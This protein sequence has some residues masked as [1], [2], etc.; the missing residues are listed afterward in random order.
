MD[1]KELKQT[2]SLETVAKDFNIPITTSHGRCPCPFC[3]SNSGFKVTK[4][5]YYLCYRCGKRGDV[6]NLL[7]DWHIAE[8]TSKAFRLLKAK[9][10]NANSVT[11]YQDYETANLI[12][13]FYR[14]CAEDV[15]K[16]LLAFLRSR[17]YPTTTLINEIGYCPE[18]LPR[19][20]DNS[21]TQALARKGHFNMGKLVFQNRV[22]F[23]VKDSCGRIVHYTGRS[24]DPLAELRWFHSTGTPP[25][26]NYLYGLHNIE[27][28]KT[29]YVVI[30]EGVTDCCAL[31]EI[32]IPAVACFGINSPLAHHSYSLK[33][34]TH[35]IA[36]FDR[37]KYPLG[38]DKAGEYKSWGPITPHLIDLAIATKIP[39]FC[40]MVPS[41]PNVKDINDFLK[42]ID[43]DLREFKRHLANDAVT[44]HE[45]TF[46]LYKSDTKKHEHLWRLN[47]AVPDSDSLIKIKQYVEGHYQDWSNYVLDLL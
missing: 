38:S 31:R 7:I 19:W 36:I 16:E 26:N 28:F 2:L 20:A 46:D 40:Y 23:P 24:L 25:I 22:M 44:L 33:H 17:G 8:D 45:F 27:S 34:A 18:S 21:T 41:W 39:V 14:R 13:T 29:D 1:I 9:Y 37:D 6:F 15:N 4:D 30:T 35:L 12:Y 11:Y 3:N 47:Q 32:N 5:V 10:G 43:F 42:E